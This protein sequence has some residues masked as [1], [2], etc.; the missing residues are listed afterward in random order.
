MCV[1]EAMTFLGIACPKIPWISLG[2]IL[3]LTDNFLFISRQGYTNSV[4][5]NKFLVIDDE[6]RHVYVALK[7]SNFDHVYPKKSVAELS[8]PDTAFAEPEK[9]LYGSRP[10]LSKNEWM[11]QN[12]R[13]LAAQI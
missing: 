9:R 3:H 2:Q 10:N 4:K 8:K 1:Y 5:S 12:G 7:A 6:D 11:R 13:P